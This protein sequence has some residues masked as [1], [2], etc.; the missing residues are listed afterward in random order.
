MPDLETVEPTPEPLSA[1]DIAAHYSRHG[2]TSERM[3]VSTRAA[4]WAMSDEGLNGTAI[5]K[6]LA[7]DGRTVHAALRIRDRDARFVRQSLMASAQDAAQAW[8]DS[9]AYAAVKGDHK[10]ARDLLLHTGYIDPIDRAQHAQTNVQIVLH[11][12]SA[13]SEL[14]QVIEVSPA[15]VVESSETLQ[16]QA[17]L[18]ESLISHVTLPV[19]EPPQ[20]TQAQQVSPPPRKRK[21]RQ[22]NPMGAEGIPKQ[23]R[24]ATFVADSSK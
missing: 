12:G 1:E 18:P 3:P 9:L 14:H 24:P 10:P 8:H 21:P 19:A 23:P 11:G 17:Q 2:I 22:R 5:A 4:I 15:K 20:V 16:I 7:L 6:A 13:P